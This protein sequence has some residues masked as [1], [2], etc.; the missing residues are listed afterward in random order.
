MTSA[1]ML[2]LNG[3][4]PVKNWAVLFAANQDPRTHNADMDSGAR[5]VISQ[6]SQLCR[7]AWSD[8]CPM[9]HELPTFSQTVKVCQYSK[10]SSQLTVLVSS[11]RYALKTADSG[12]LT[13]RLVDVAQDVIIREDDCGTDRNLWSC[14]ITELKEMIESRRASQTVK[15]QEIA[16]HPET[17]G[18]H[19]SK[20]IDYRRQGSWNRQCRYEEVTTA[21][22]TCGSL[23]AV[24][25]LLL[26]I[27]LATGDV[28]AGKAA[29]TIAV[30]PF[31]PAHSL[32]CNL[33]HGCCLN[34]DITS[35][36]VQNLKPAILKGKYTRSQREVT[37]GK[38]MSTASR[39]SS[40]KVKLAKANNEPFTA[41]M[42]VGS[43]R[44]YCGAALQKGSIQPKRLLR[45]KVNGKTN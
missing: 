13:C 25:T 10:C 21:L 7:Y 39:K 3:M 16:K 36:L 27:N 19:W 20:W 26:R 12:Y 24:F 45:L 33:P 11:D 17:S 32:Q 38:K 30:Y 42:R 2:L 41:R 31:K 40:L 35:L 1:T 29:G 4:L 34:T 44:S 23:V 5:G 9:Y 15:H 22:F 43:R 14:S 6:T 18:Y 28:V 37:I 8:G